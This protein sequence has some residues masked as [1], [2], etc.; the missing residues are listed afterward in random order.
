MHAGHNWFLTNKRLL[1]SYL[2]TDPQPSSLCGTRQKRSQILGSFLTPVCNV[3]I[4]V[5]VKVGR[6][7][8][9]H[10]PYIHSGFKISF[11]RIL[12]EMANLELAVLV[13]VLL[14]TLQVL[15]QKNIRSEF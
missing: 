14:R 9:D 3:I 12:Q 1:V 10:R 5:Q 6:T 11:V 2:H 7:Q 4:N 8:E 13:Y 15:C